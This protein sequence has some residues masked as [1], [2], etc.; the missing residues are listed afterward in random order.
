MSFIRTWTPPQSRSFKEYG[1]KKYGYNLTDKKAGIG[2]KR[3][4]RHGNWLD[5]RLNYEF[6]DRCKET[7]CRIV[8]P[9]GY[10]NKFKYDG[11][12][13]MEIRLS[14]MPWSHGSYL[15]IR[16][17]Y[18]DK[19]TSNGIL[20]H[21]DVMA[22]ILPDLIAAV[23]KMEAEDT[24]EPEQKSKIVFLPLEDGHEEN[25]FREVETRPYVGQ[26]V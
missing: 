4:H 25:E 11:V 22:A 18:G 1:I 13:K 19:S 16:K 7:V 17:Y 12:T 3:F 14:I 9:S 10:H 15:D 23:R 20:L 8:H 5:G 26:E 2:N 21:V 24:R 6:L